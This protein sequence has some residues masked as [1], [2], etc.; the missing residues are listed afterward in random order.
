MPLMGIRIDAFAIDTP[1]FCRALEVTLWHVLSQV[2]RR[3]P[4]DHF[5]FH[6]FEPET[7]FRYVICPD[8]RILCTSRDGAREFLQDDQLAA[9]PFLQQSCFAYLRD[10][11]SSGY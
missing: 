10:P 3:A 11:N 5:L 6:V 2:A 7:Q 1:R 8:G 9:S 4:R